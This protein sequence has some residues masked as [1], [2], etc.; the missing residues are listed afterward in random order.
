MYCMYVLK[1]L[2]TMHSIWTARVL[3]CDVPQGWLPQTLL[4]PIGLGRLTGVIPALLS[5]SL[6]ST[7][8]KGPPFL[9][10]PFADG[11]GG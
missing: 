9:P 2:L 11:H 3:L 6:H 10:G 1:A 8:T 7:D 4:I 5:S